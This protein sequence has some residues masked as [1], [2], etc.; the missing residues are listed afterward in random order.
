MRLQYG[1]ETSLR[2]GLGNLLLVGAT[3]RLDLVRPVRNGAGPGRHAEL[4]QSNRRV[5]RDCGRQE[6]DAGAGGDLQGPE[7]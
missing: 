5:R 1:D 4:D 3:P 6:R 7:A 2:L